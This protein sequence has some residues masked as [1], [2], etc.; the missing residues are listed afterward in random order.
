MLY[1]ISPANEQLAL[2]IQGQL[3]EVGITAN[4]RAIEPVQAG[5]IF[6]VR[7]ESNALAALWG[8]RPDATQTFR[9]LYSDTG[10]SNPGRHTT[11][12]MM[13]AIDETAQVQPE[14]ER[15]ASLQ[16]ASAQVVTDVLDIVTFF[17]VTSYSFADNVLG[18]ERWGFGRPDFRYVGIAAS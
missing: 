14:E 3:A 17:P 10:F 7:Q 2:A 5:D 15:N 8:G 18:V 1:Q 4:V 13:A 9:L 11:P 6:Y 12:E 16:R